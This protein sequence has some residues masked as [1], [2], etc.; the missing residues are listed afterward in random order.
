[1]QGFTMGGGVGVSCHGSHRIVCENSRIAMPECGI[2]LV[3]DVGGSLLLARAP[4]RLGEYL[5]STGTRMGADDAIFAGFADYFIARGNWPALI[6]ELEKTGDY[7]AIDAAANTPPK[8]GMRDILPEIDCHFGG[9]TMGDILRSL[10]HAP[11][12][13]TDATRVTLGRQSP[14]SLACLIELIHRVRATDTIE[15]ALAQ[16]YRFTYRAAQLG[17]FVEGIRAAIIDR[18]KTPVWRHKHI[19]DV[20]SVDMSN[21]LLPLGVNT[22]KL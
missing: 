20:S 12:E 1:M 18:D 2:G 16:E 6:D 14:L 11:S 4:G 15:K 9:E 5:G 17:D 3:P 21:M 8:G 7:R 22:L 13:F 10:E 19:D